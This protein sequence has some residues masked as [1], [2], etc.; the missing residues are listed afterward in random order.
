MDVRVYNY[1]Y[2]RVEYPVERGY[3][4]EISPL[5]DWIYI[6]ISDNN[7]S[8]FLTVH[9]SLHINKE[10]VVGPE[11]SVN[12]SDKDIIKDLSGEVSSRFL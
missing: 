10:V 2:V 4:I 1:L 3:R 11:Y 12:F 5:P 8:K 9:S 6:T 7:N